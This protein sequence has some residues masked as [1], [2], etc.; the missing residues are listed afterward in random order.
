MKPITRAIVIIE[1][2]FPTVPAKILRDTY[3][4]EAVVNEK[5]HMLA[6]GTSVMLGGDEDDLKD[7]LRA[8]GGTVWSSNNPMMGNWEKLEVAKI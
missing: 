8:C 7:Y 5:G 6:V 4:Y 2:G 3:G 1:E